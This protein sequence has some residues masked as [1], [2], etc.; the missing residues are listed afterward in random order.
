[1][2]EINYLTLEGMAD[3]NFYSTTPYARGRHKEYRLKK[4]YEREGCI[5]I[6]SSGSHSPVDL[7][8]IDYNEKKIKLIQ[9]KLNLKYGVKEKLEAENSNLNGVYDV[10]YIAE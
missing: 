7:V 5:V 6:R 8:V 4:K 10:E 3:A 9:S 2:I 1:M